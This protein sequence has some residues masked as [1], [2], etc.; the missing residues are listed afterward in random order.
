M[1]KSL[2][3]IL[4]EEDR[5]VKKI[6]EANSDADYTMRWRDKVATFPD[7]SLKVA[8]LARYDG[9]IA[10]CHRKAEEYRKQLD[11]VRDDLR[12]YL[13]ELFK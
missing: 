6:H 5:L 13:S 2:L 8:D 11:A 4:N 1:E 12:A 3:S 10:D 9:E 7:C